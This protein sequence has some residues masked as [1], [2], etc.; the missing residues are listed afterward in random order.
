[1]SKKPQICSKLQPDDL[2]ILIFTTECDRF[3][4]QNPR[5][6]MVRCDGSGG[7]RKEGAVVVVGVKQL[8]GWWSR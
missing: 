8:A 6:A 1:M 5:A 7:D 3:Q 4:N 2:P